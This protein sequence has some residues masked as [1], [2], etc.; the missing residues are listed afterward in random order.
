MSKE[1][2]DEYLS[3]NQAALL[4]CLYRAISRYKTNRM[5]SPDSVEIAA[6]A[7][8]LFPDIGTINPREITGFVKSPEAM[9][10]IKIS[11]LPNLRESLDA[12]IQKTSQYPVL[13]RFLLTTRIIT[14]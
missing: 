9:E 7:Y 2:N 3:H 5:W 8:E 14:F 12:A 10:L 4:G 6:Y 13:T 11:P 1:S